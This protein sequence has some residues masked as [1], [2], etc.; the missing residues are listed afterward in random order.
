MFVYLITNRIN[1]K[2]YVGQHA[3]K[4]LQKYFERTVWMALHGYQGKR[5]LYRAIR[6][7]GV[8]NFAI[9][10][11]VIVNN[12]WEMDLYETRLIES[13]DLRNPEKGYNLTKGGDGT[14]GFYPDDETRQKMSKSH[15]GKKMSEENRLKFIERNKGNKYALGRKMTEEHFQKIL[16]THL[17]AKRSEESR[18]RMSD[19]Q[20]GKKQSEETKIKRAAALKGQKRSEETK[21]KMSESLM[22]NGTGSHIRW[23]VNK[24]IV[25]PQ[26]VLCREASNV[27]ASQSGIPRNQ[28]QPN[29]INARS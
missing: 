20:K 29:S 17:G 8:E 13:F 18:K 14:L 25:N 15:F 21:R 16:A 12:K 9:S 26:C 19:A 5:L 7:Y 2:K 10:P 22:G 24:G 4:D 3:G 28:E 6:K 11:I 1:N 27:L 23:H